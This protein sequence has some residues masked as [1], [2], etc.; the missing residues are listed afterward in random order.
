MLARY[1]STA[2]MIPVLMIAWFG[3]GGG[4]GFSASLMVPQST[5][6]TKQSP[7]ASGRALRIPHDLPFNVVDSKR[8]SEGAGVAST[9][10]DPAGTAVCVAD[11]SRGGSAV[12]EFQ[13]G[14][15]LTHDAADPVDV[16]IVFDVAYVCKT[17]TTKQVYGV[18]PLQL[19][20]YVMDSDRNV[21]GKL[22][23]AES[24]P[25]RLPEKWTGSQSPSFAV[26]LQPGLAYHLVVA[27]R[28]E[29]SATDAPGPS[30]SVEI[31]S[32][33]IAIAPAG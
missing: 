14:H 12:A 29:A 6:R 13:L 1:L 9:S 4:G 11:A 26:T 24:D 3:C 10:V 27:G 25:D 28:V 32:L 30:A 33:V 20:A 19:N 17:S 31:T 7:I 21:L 23:L 22:K 18:Q 15:V 2:T 16:T 8:T 5:Y